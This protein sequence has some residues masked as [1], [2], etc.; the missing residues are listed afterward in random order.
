MIELG[1]KIK[2]NGF[3][4]LD[5]AAIIVV[6]KM[7]GSFAKKFIEKKGLYE[8]FEITHENNQ[9]SASIILNNNTTNHT[10]KQEN[11]FFSL[12]ETLEGLK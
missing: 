5:P 6:K 9:I 1:D 12:S 8:L 2:L 7:V 11:L 10:S 4:N 3:D